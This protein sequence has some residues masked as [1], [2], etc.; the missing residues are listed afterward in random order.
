MCVQTVKNGVPGAIPTR[1]LP[2]RSQIHEPFVFNGYEKA[3]RKHLIIGM[4]H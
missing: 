3:G 1:N 4:A 2:P